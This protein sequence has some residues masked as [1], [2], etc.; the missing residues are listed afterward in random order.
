MRTIQSKLKT[1]TR[2][3]EF[4]FP[5][6][7][8]LGRTYDLLPPKRTPVV[9][10]W[11]LLQH[12]CWVSLCVLLPDCYNALFGSTTI[13]LVGYQAN[14]NIHHFLGSLSD[15]CQD[16][17]ATYTYQIM[18]ATHWLDMASVQCSE[19]KFYACQEWKEVN[20]CLDS[21]AVSLF[22]STLIWQEPKELWLLDEL[23]C[24]M[25]SST[26]SASCRFHR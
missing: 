16:C 12:P 14:K 8:C 24:L 15:L 9:I 1:L 18:D 11:W 23:A 26:E 6:T 20:V 21:V 7:C 17:G 10:W 13:S 22:D 3:P 5:S 19:L 2:V 4:F 25:L